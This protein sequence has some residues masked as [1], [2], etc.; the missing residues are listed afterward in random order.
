MLWH[1]IP[2]INYSSGFGKIYLKT[3]P[4]A[5]PENQLAR[6]FHDLLPRFSP[7]YHNQQFY[8]KLNLPMI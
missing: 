4:A 3:V 2:G 7:L 8:I 5:H 6:E 1:E